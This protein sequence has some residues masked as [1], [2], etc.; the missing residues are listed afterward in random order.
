MDNQAQRR[1]HFHRGRRGPDRRGQE[2]RTPPAQEQANRDHVDVEQ[3]MRDIRARIS[4]RHGIDLT[5]QQI[6]ELAARRLEAILDPRAV[7][8]ALLDQLRKSAGAQPDPAAASQGEPPYTFAEG[9]VFESHRGVIRLLR[10]LFKPLL[11][12]F[13]NPTPVERALAA[14]SRLNVDAAQRDAE[15]Q[16]QQVEWNALHYEI[17]QRLVTEVSRASLDMQ[18]L[19]AQVES[20]AAK[21]DFNERRVRHMEGSLHQARPSGRQAEPAAAAAPPRE[22]PPPRELPPP[23]EPPPPREAAPTAETA[24]SAEPGAETPQTGEATR[25]RRR[26]RRGRRGGGVPGEGAPQH[27]AALATPAAGAEALPEEPDDEGDD[28]ED[29]PVESAPAISSEPDSVPVVHAHGQAADMP[30][31]PEPAPPPILAHVPAPEPEPVAAAAAPE[32]ISEPI[33]DSTPEPTPEPQQWAPPPADSETD[34]KE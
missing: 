28:G 26:R 11:M 13:I 22:P 15:R 2:R 17:L 31:E 10:K 27:A 29:T 1:G 32:P 24:P 20:L 21:V 23:R 34:R 6:Q 8:P 33:F 5:T 9:A 25:R 18:S 14:Q 4:Q 7:K 19:S 30:A 16:R 3:I 12:L